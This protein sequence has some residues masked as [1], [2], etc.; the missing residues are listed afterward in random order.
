[1]VKRQDEVVKQFQYRDNGAGLGWLLDP[2]ARQVHIYRPGK[3][4]ELLHDPTII[5]GEPLLK[6]FQLDVRRLWA[7]M[8]R[9]K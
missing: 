8:E 4:P 2:S 6:G 7:V 5:S 3:Q 9:R 1:M